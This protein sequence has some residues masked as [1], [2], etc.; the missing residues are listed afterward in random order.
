MEQVTMRGVHFEPAVACRIGPPG[1][2]DEFGDD[3]VD[4]RLRQLVRRR[5]SRVEW[6]RGCADRFPCPFVLSQWPALQFLRV[7]L[8]RR[9]AGSLAAGMSELNARHSALRGDEAGHPS[10]TRGVRITPDAEV[11]WGNAPFGNYGGRLGA[12]QSRATNCARAQVH[13]MP[14]VDLA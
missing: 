5:V 9:N 2:G 7:V 11:R 4:F 6:N 14:I 12:H 8:P 13:E 3:L 10:M 1:G